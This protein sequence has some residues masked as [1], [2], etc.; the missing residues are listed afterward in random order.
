MIAK[1]E[2]LALVNRARA[3]RLELDQ[4]FA[5]LAHWNDTIRRPDEAPLHPDP[6]GHLRLMARTLDRWLQQERPEGH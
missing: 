6:D 1:Q 2:R 5:D 3:L 4:H